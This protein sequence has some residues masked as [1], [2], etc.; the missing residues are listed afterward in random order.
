LDAVLGKLLRSR[1][2]NLLVGFDKAD[3][4]GVYRLSPDLALVQTVDFFTPIVDDPYIFGQIA[5]ANSLSDVYAMGGRPLTALAIVGFPEREPP[6][7]LETIFQGGLSKLQEAGCTLAGGHSIRDEELKFGYAITGTVHPGR[8]LTNA[9]ARPGDRLVLTKALGTGVIATAAK[10]GKV[11]SAHE[12]ASI[13]SMQLLNRAACERMLEFQPDAATDI[14]GFGLLGHARELAA[15]SNVALQI[16]AA[17]VPLL[18]GALDY[19]TDFQSKGLKD[20]RAFAECAV[21]FAA[22]IP[23]AM[24]AL[25]FDPQTS[26]GLLIALPTDRARALAAALG[27]PASVIGEVVE[28]KPGAPLIRLV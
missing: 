4:A 7:L 11:N 1:D 19:A 28:R 25:L 3:D 16:D 21:S 9:G 14:T 18:T 8:V 17:A 12:A 20:N 24:R 10:R 2:P 22:D 6:E 15:G 13:A 26:G 5:A 23:E 27:P